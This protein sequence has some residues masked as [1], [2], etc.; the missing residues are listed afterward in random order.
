MH[1]KY[2]TGIFDNT[3][4]GGVYSLSTKSQSVTWSFFPKLLLLWKPEVNG[5]NLSHASLQS[6]FFLIE[7]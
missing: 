5:S 2:I 7:V 6:S 4:N 1:Q 3:S